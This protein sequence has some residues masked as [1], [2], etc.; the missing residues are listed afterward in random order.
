[1]DNKAYLDEIAVKGKKKFS[2][3]PIMTPFMLK[4][5]IVGVFAVIAMI[6]V[7]VMLS[8]RNDNSAASHEA[9]YF[10]MNS[11][12][13]KHGAIQSYIKKVKAS[14]LRSYTSTLLSSLTT[15]TSAI[16][17]AAGRIGLNT[18]S[19]SSEVATQN[20]RMMTQY[21]MELEEAYLTGTL[22]VTYASSTAYQ[23]SLLLSL[24]NIARTKTSDS[25]YAKALDD[26]IRDLTAL[27][28]LFQTYADTH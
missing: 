19:A 15:S 7:G 18:G 11:L 16:K 23:L 12:M 17:S 8:S 6:I 28:E 14:E 5:V 25:A 20:S 3:G 2:A 13:D 26:S 4:L 24:E 21:E 10:R 27:E 22:D 1:M 9:V